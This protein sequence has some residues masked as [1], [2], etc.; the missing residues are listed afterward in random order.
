MLEYKA[1]NQNTKLDHLSK[2]KRV[3]YL[4]RLQMYIVWNFRSYTFKRKRKRPHAALKFGQIY[5][6][7]FIA[8]MSLKYK[9]KNLLITIFRDFCLF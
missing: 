2:I 7:L 5:Y 1:I 3:T 6:F 8:L 4:L 9:I